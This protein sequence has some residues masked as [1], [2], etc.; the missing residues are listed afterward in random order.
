MSLCKCAAVGCHNE[1]PPGRDRCD[2]CARR[3]LA[4]GYRG[5]RR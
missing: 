4:S 3:D 2:E 5:G 1:V